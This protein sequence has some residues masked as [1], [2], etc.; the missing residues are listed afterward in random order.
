MKTFL[1]PSFYFPISI[2][3][4]QQADSTEHALLHNFQFWSFKHSIH[5][6]QRNTPT[7]MKSPSNEDYFITSDRN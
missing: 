2:S 3:L 6:L 4:P 7:S 5:N 1:V